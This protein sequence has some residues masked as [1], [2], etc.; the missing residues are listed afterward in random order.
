VLIIMSVTTTTMFF[1][2]ANSIKNAQKDTNQQNI[3]FVVNAINDFYIRTGYIPCPASLTEAPSTLNFGVSTVCNAVAVAGVNDV[4]SGADIV[5]RGMIPVRTMGLPD[6]AAYDAYGNRIQYTIVRSFGVN[7]STFD[8]SSPSTGAITVFGYN[9]TGPTLTNL[10]V[11]TSPN[12][13]AY[14]VHSSGQDQN[15]AVT[16]RGV[17]LTCT[18]GGPNEY[19]C[20][21]T[22]NQFVG[23]ADISGTF[24]DVVVWKTRQQLKYDKV[25]FFSSSRN[26]DQTYGKIA[27]FSDTRGAGTPSYGTGAAGASYYQRNLNTVQVNNLSNGSLANNSITL[28]AGTYKISAIASS[29]GVNRNLLEIYSAT[30]NSVLISG[31]A[32]YADSTVAPTDC[33]DAFLLGVITLTR[34]ETIYLRHYVQT[35][36]ITDGFGRSINSGYNQTYTTLEILEM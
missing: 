27:I 20:D 16:F 8:S 22:Y 11:L 28:G 26:A 1:F 5:R 32:G 7:A 30:S 25:A 17:P 12:T 21:T 13:I 34:T 2:L 36:N 35:A 3:D 10:N 23:S 6:A 14:V 4:G 29:C 9:P 24:D 33:R 15:G 18:S 31:L 19:N